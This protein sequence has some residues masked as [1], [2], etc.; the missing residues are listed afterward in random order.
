M[1]APRRKRKRWGKGEGSIR[2]CDRWLESLPRV[3]TT[4]TLAT[5]GLAGDLAS[6]CLS[7]HICKVGI[8]KLAAS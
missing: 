5:D 1:R 7:F 6:L 3:T 4:R 2:R 8:L